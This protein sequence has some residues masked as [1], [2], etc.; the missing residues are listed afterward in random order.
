MNFLVE[1]ILQ[2][3]P[4]DLDLDGDVDFVDFLQLSAHFGAAE[5]SWDT[6]DMDGD[7]RTG[8]ADFLLLASAVATPL[9]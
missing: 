9:G 8:F 4:G 7:G 3:R 1:D 2:T 6:G 5:S